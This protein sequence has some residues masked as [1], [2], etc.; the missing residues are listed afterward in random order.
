MYTIKLAD[1]TQLKKLELNGNNYIAPSLIE[2]SVFE[3]NL[4]TVTISDGSTT[5]TFEDMVLVQNTTYGDGKS[6]FVLAPKSPE[7]KER[8]YIHGALANTELLST[9]PFVI[10]A[11]NGDI[12]DVTITEHADVFVTW[13]EHWTGKAGT[14]VNDEGNL[15]R[16]IHDVGEGQNTKPSE[17]PAMWTRIGNP[18]EEYPEWI[19]PIGAH[20]AYSIGDKVTHNDARWV[21]TADGNVWEPGV[22]GWDE[23]K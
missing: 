22:Y 5:E 10:M 16:S 9:I 3:N 11:Q 6:W 2:G 12:D 7:Q 13:D 19:A 8:E 23:V 1:G 18:A 17:T 15:Y 4:S 21:S 20:D 14:I